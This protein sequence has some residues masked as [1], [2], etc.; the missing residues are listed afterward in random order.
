MLTLAL[1]FMLLMT[2]EEWFLRTFE[3][4]SIY[5]FDATRV[6]PEDAGE[7]R[8][9]EVTLETTDGEVLILWVG[10]PENAVATILYLPGNAGNLAPRADRFSHF[11]DLDYGVVALGYRGSSGSSGRPNEAALSSDALLVFD[12]VQA[13]AGTTNGAI[14]LYG[15]SLGTALA[16]K[17]AAQRTAKGVILEAPCTSIPDLAKI[18]Y[19]GIDLSGILTEFWDTAAIIGDMDEPLLILHGADDQL[20]PLAQ[21]QTI[22]ALAGSTQ[23]WMEALPG[24]G[25]QGLWTETALAALDAFLERL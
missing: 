7:G 2:Y 4:Q 10:M 1:P 23:K 3:M 21:G 14:I 9:R 18:Q 6:D 11:L 24:V 8:L 25:H 12:S 17:I 13:L 22:F 16:A 20:V 5:P 19:P 15:E